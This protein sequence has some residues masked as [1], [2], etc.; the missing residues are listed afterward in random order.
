MNWNKEHW[1]LCI[2]D[3]IS[4]QVFI[5]DS[6]PDSNAVNKERENN[7]KIVCAAI[8]EA[9]SYGFGHGHKGDVNNY[10]F[11][12]PENC[13]KQ[14]NGNDCGIYIAKFMEHCG[15]V[16]S[17]FKLHVTSL[18]RLRI[19]FDLFLDLGNEVRHLC[20]YDFA[21]LENLFG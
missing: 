1:Y 3:I 15:D 13:P 7:A 16:K 20:V 11:T 21:G 4:R 6:A 17:G 12:M 2:I 8:E 18:D 14:G 19:A 9:L 10:K 5:C